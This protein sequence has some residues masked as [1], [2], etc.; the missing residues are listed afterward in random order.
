M[1]EQLSQYSLSTADWRKVLRQNNWRTRIV[2]ILFFLIYGSIGMLVDMYMVSTMYPHA[3]LPQIFHALVT[4]KVFPLA[5][6]ILIVIAAVSL[7]VSYLF[8]DKLML[9]GTEYHEITPTTAQNMTE[10]Q[11]YNVVEE[12]KIAAGLRYMPRVFIIDAD[13]MNAFASGYSEKSALVAITRGL[14]EKLN[15]SELQAVMA[16]E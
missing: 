6:T 13:Y 3:A 9:L 10:Q 15:R 11:L 2:I 8:Y 1:S 7:M 16:H 4:F 14:M 12:M 5:T